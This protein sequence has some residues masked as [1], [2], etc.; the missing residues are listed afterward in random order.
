MTDNGEVLQKLEEI[1]VMLETLAEN[2]RLFEEEVLEKFDNLS[3]PGPDWQELD[4]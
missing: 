1:W 4:S 3:L 2:Q